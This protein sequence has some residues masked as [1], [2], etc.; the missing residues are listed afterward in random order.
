MHGYSYFHRLWASKRD[1]GELVTPAV[2]IVERILVRAGCTRS[3]AQALIR[4]VKAAQS[5]AGEE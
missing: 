2:R 1:A 5:E 4:D 3:E